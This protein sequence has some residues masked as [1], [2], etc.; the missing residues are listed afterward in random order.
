MSTALAFSLIRLFQEHAYQPFR[1]EGATVLPI[2][3]SIQFAEKDEEC[4]LHT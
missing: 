4:G 1:P 3:V 2:Q